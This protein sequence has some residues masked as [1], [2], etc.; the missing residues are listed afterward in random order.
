MLCIYMYLATGMSA[1]HTARK[2]RAVNRDA[3]PTW[4]TATSEVTPRS[5]R[6]HARPLTSTW[7]GAALVTRA[8]EF[9]GLCITQSLT[10]R[11][12]FSSEELQ[13]EWHFRRCGPNCLTLAK[14]LPHV[15][16]VAIN[17]AKHNTHNFSPPGSPGLIVLKNSTPWASLVTKR[18]SF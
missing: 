15:R 17:H 13:L 12:T 1:I 16:H 14:Y 8:F 3:V 10:V 18:E 7:T 11:V 6:R 4:G 5:P 2:S 9:V